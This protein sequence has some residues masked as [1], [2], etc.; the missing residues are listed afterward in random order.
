[1][2]DHQNKLNK[3]LNEQSKPVISQTYT[4]NIRVD[5]IMMQKT[6]KNRHSD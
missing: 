4:G 3:N 5:T 1:M 6:N 2:N